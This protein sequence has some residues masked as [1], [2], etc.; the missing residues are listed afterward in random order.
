MILVAGGTGRLGTL[1]T[2]ALTE[3]GDQVRVLT[4]NPRRA[5]Q[6]IGSGA[7]VVEGDVRNPNTLTDAFAGVDTV[8]SAIQGFAGLG[9][10]SPRAVDS[11]G[12]SHLISAA[13]D[14]NADVVLVSVVGASADSPMELF[15]CK[16]VA[17]Q[18]LKASGLPWTIVRATAFAEMWADILRKGIVLGQGDNPI[19][20][21]SVRDVAAAVTDA[22]LDTAL[23]GQILEIGGPDNMTFNQF[24]ALLKQLRGTPARV[25][26]LPRPLLRTLAPLHRQ[27]RAALTMDTAD[28]TFHP[29]AGARNYGPTSLREALGRPVMDAS[30]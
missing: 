13:V 17:E 22:A 8:V 25:R 26:H 27:P 18:K 9:R 30:H 29:G 12:N 7:E 28:M 15:R 23:R 16:Y 20:F 5:E 24:A 14:A 2:A 10:V 11:D 19:N 4:R 1:V 6:L 3:R 21:V